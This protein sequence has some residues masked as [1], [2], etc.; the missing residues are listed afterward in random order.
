MPDQRI[1][2]LLDMGMSAQEAEKVVV[3][4]DKV[5]R[6]GEGRPTPMRC[7]IPSSPRACGIVGTYDSSSSAR[8]TSSWTGV[9]RTAMEATQAQKAM[10]Q[11]MGEMGTPSPPTATAGLRAAD[12]QAAAAG[13]PGMGV[14][15]ASYA[16][17]DFIAVLPAAARA[18]AGR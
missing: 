2:L 7:S 4:L 3:A 10:Q 1:T 9:V 12:R 16:F 5:R 8:K 18:S 14:M 6:R 17:Q 13:G 15:G 11:V